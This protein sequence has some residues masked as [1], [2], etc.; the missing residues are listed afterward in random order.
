MKEVKDKKITFK[1]STSLFNRIEEF[2]EESDFENKSQ[3]MRK[4]IEDKLDGS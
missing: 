4:L 2:I 3:L 1:L